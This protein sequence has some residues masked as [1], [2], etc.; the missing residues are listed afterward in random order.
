MNVIQV[1]YLIQVVLPQ[2]LACDMLDHTERKA[3]W[4]SEK[5]LS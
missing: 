1:S 2:A 3:D 4:G 5:V